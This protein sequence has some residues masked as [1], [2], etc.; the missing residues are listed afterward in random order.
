MLPL[1]L[2]VKGGERG[3]KPR[4]DRPMEREGEGER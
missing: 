3:L 1:E 4:G 2:H